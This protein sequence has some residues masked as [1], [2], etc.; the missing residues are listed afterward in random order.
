VQGTDKARLDAESTAELKM[1]CTGVVSVVSPKTP[2]PEGLF[3]TN[4]EIRWGIM[5]MLSG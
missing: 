4:A 3:R 2:I 1:V 5:A